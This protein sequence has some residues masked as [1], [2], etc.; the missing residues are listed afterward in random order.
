[1]TK[2]CSKCK[3]E[4]P[5]KAFSKCKPR[6]DGFH[7]KCKACNKVDNDKSNPVHNPKNADYRRERDLRIKYDMTV[8]DYNEMLQAQDGVC[9]ICF[10]VNANGD[11]LAVDH[12]H[13]SLE[14][15]GLLCR[16]CNGG[17][18]YFKEDVV[19]LASAIEYLNNV[20]AYCDR[21]QDID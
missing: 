8:E 13:D 17:I 4:K 9:A 16:S 7:D 21:T 3:T 1:M 10:H 18:G 12:C 6:K 14:N 19:Y 2:I 20:G 5:L 15:R 11:R